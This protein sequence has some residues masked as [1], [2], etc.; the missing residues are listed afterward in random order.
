MTSAWIGGA[1]MTAFGRTGIGLRGLTEQVVRDVLADAGI[2]A[3]E[4]DQVFFGNAA[5]GLLQGQEMVR[6]QVLLRDT[7]LLGRPVFNVENACASSSSA[8]HLAVAAVQGGQADVVLAVGVEQLVVPSR[9]RTFAALAAATD[10]ERRPEM[11]AI[12][13]AYALKE[14]DPAGID[15]TA[16]PFMAHYAGKALAYMREFGATA[17]DLARIV[18][19]SRDNGARNP[20]AQ[21]GDR[22]T[23][24]EVLASRMISDPLRLPMCAPIGD[25][26]AAVVVLSDSAARRLGRAEV[27][28]RAVALMSNDPASPVSPTRAAANR[29]YERAGIGPADLDLVELHDAAASAELVVPE[30]LGLCGAGGAVELVRKGATAL[31]GELPINP[32]GGLLSRGHPLGATGCAQIV[33]LADQLRGRCGDRQ[34][35]SPRMGLAQNAGGVLDGDEAVVAVSILEKAGT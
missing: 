14:R 18:V 30:E 32:S 9:T 24:D 27:R 17:D 29:A 20:K 34:V 33:E 25:G 12:V 1:A 11:R 15:L 26:A 35:R 21:F 13:E 2:D 4:V 31:D 8:F 10:T 7:G 6:G 16:S 22:T 3:G 23:V 19:K 5:A 28:V